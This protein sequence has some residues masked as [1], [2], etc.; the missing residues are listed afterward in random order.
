MGKIYA[1]VR[2][3]SKDQNIARQLAAL[4]A[5]HLD[6]KFI[7][8]DKLSGKDFNRPGYGKLLKRVKEGDLIIVKS[9]DRLGRNYD[10]IIEQWRLIT[11]DK[12]VDIKVLDMPLLDTTLS[13][14]I[15]G[16]FIA[17]LVLQ[18][19]S[20]CAHEE[21]SN[22]KQRQ[23]EGIEAAKKRG[24]KFGRRPCVLPCQ[25]NDIVCDFNQKRIKEQEALQ[26]LKMSRTTFYK[27]KK[28]YQ[29]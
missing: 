15:L 19:L 21:R 18:V 13:K 5:F 6:K 16:T 28:E 24:V 10:E 1:Y 11:K 4:E 9:I 22:I 14:D 2:V 25:F 3:S 29:K 8:V 20:F 27:Y 26:I 12:G 23:K 17:D 7:Y